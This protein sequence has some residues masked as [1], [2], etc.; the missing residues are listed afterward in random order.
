VCT[1]RTER[2]TISG[3]GKGPD[4]WVALANASVYYDHP[5]H[6]QLEH[7][8]NIDLFSPAADG[9]LRIAVELDRDSAIALARAVL[10]LVEA[11]PV[12]VDAAAS[13]PL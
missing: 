12:D 9:P 7:S 10:A 11:F 8:L 6:A 5:F 2:I 4:G 3:S 13:V 1:Y